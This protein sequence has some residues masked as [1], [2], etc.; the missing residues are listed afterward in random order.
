[1]IAVISHDAGGAE[2][3]SSYVL[4]NDLNC[5]FVVEGPAQKIFE[6]KLGSFDNHPLE[7]AII[8]S[9]SILCGTSWQ[10]DLELEALR[11][12]RTHGKRSVAFIDHW[13][14]YEERFHRLDG[15]VLPDEIWVVDEMAEALAKRTFPNLPIRLFDNPYLKQIRLELANIPLV[16][17]TGVGTISVLYVC[18]PI[19]EHALLRHGDAHHWGYVESEALHYFLSNCSALDQPV[20][21]IVIR[22]HPSESEGKYDWVLQ[23]FELPIEIGGHQSLLSDIIESDYVIGCESMAMVVALLAEKRVISSIPPGGRP[24]VLPHE[25]IERLQD[26]VGSENLTIMQNGG[27]NSG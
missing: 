6:R 25:E 16:E 17:S 21:R 26:L 23:E 2:I 5:I 9:D 18:E 4:E 20:G 1:M 10:S 24:C 12:G 8:Q 22:P 11:L 13:V 19:G 3:L 27:P 14:N 7:Q 15:L